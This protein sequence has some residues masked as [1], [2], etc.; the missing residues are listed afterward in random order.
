[1]QYTNSFLGGTPEAARIASVSLLGLGSVT[2]AFNQ[3]QRF[4]PIA[5]QQASGGLTITAPANGNVAPPGYYLLFPV[6]T[7]GVPSVA[8]IVRISSGPADTQAPTA[9]A[10]LAATAASS[11]Q[12]NLSWTAST[13]DVGVAS[14]FVERCAGSG[15]TNFQQIGTAT[16]PS[17]ADTGLTT[18]TSYSYQVRA[19]D[20]A[21]N[22]SG[23]SNVATATASGPPPSSGLVA[24]YAFSEGSGTTTTDAT[25]KGHTGTLLGSATCTTAGKHGQGPPRNGSTAYVDL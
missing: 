1:M 15:C 14:Y 21:N 9:P 25:G 5:F 22:L 13:D 12:I 10:N 2:H 19:S 4:V 11:V 20:G 3:A 24:A 8:P 23:Y 6:D 16:T 7:N 17:Y 18:G